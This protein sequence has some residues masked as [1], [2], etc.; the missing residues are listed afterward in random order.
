MST[1]PSTK[2]GRLSRAFGGFLVLLPVIALIAV[3]QGCGPREESRPVRETVKR[4]VTKKPTATP[5]PPEDGSTQAEQTQQHAQEML[6]QILDEQKQAL[7]EA[8]AQRQT[9]LALHNENERQRRDDEEARL[10]REERAA[11]Q[12]RA[13]AARQ[14][15]E[16]E[17]LRQEQEELLALREAREV[18]R[19]EAG[20]QAQRES[21]ERARLEDEALLASLEAEPDETTWDDIHDD[22]PDIQTESTVSMGLQKKGWKISGDLRPILDGL[23]EESRDGSTSSDMAPGIRA[24][25]GADFG[26]NRWL[27]VGTRVAG[28][29]FLGNFNPNFILPGNNPEGSDLES[30]T[31]GF[32]QLYLRWQ[33]KDRFSLAVGRLQTRFQLRG[34]V[35]AKSLDRN[36]SHNW[37]VNWTDGL[38][39]TL[40]TGGWQSSFVL[41]V[42]PESGPTGV[43][44]NP[45]DFH[46]DDARLTYFLAFENFENKGVLV[47]RAF[48]IS[49][50]PASL[51]KDGDPEGRR[52]D[53]WGFVGR[54]MFVWPPKS[55]GLRLRAGPEIGYAPETPTYAA[56][57]LPGTGDVS[58]FAWN[59]VISAMDF[60]PGHSIGLNY[61]RTEAGWL[62]SPQYR[63]NHE[64]IELR[65]MWRSKKFPLLE[66]RIR[67]RTELQQQIGTVRPRT[68]WDFFIRATIR[69]TLL[70]Q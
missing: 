49:Y 22:T 23:H 50:L 38:Q 66:T 18:A 45:L 9:A 39:A 34:G 1:K 46:N 60:K 12:R 51:L 52:V 27:S 28:T 70:E 32:D 3:I 64:L 24:R 56:M 54:L 63:P 59:V 29:G 4:V 68:Q 8:E 6:R 17:R 7:A 15:R 62:L 55:E 43:R 26:I 5:V 41:Q 2:P 58:G 37:R 14:R 48:D 31:F 61:A 10:A 30:G 57:D 13:A 65:H 47:Q 67:R 21:E 35:Y 40:K 33:R 16:A 36:N 42:N 53:Y 19:R 11:E 44:R 69:F 25:I 20:L